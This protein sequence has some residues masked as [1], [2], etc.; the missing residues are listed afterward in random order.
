MQSN[1]VKDNRSQM[2]QLLV[3]HNFLIHLFIYRCIFFYETM[4]A[5]KGSTQILISRPA[6]NMLAISFKEI[7]N[8]FF[9]P[10]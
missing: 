8:E 1:N 7:N 3:F 10:L 2:A 6:A 5:E 9:L 4:K